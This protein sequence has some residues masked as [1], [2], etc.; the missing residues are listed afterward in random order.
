MNK[1]KKKEKSYLS[2]NFFTSHKECKTKVYSKHFDIHTNT[3][4]S[5]VFVHI[6]L[7][8]VACITVRVGIV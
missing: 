3:I 6:F 2:H 8:L 4:S 5:I 1:K 7:H